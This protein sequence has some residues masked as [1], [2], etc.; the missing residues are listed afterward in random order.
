M[1]GLG[2]STLYLIIREQPQISK[3]VRRRG[4]KRGKRLI[5]VVALREYLDGFDSGFEECGQQPV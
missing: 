1:F 5:K 3:S 4:Y 2:R